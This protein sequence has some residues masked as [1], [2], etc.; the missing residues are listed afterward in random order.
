MMETKARAAKLAGLLLQCLQSTAL[1]VQYAAP[2][3]G[4]ASKAASGKA[5]SALWLISAKPTA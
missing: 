4:N 3:P 5:T 1:D 2:H